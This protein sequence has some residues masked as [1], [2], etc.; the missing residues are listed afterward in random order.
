MHQPCQSHNW[1]NIYDID[2]TA[3]DDQF[4]M[5]D[6]DE[7]ETCSDDFDSSP[8][9]AI[10]C[11][12]S[13]GADQ[14]A[15]VPTPQTTYLP[16]TPR[17]K[18]PPNSPDAPTHND[19]E[20]ES[21]LR[22]APQR[23]VSTAPRDLW[24]DE[25][26]TDDSFIT[27]DS[28]LTARSH[29]LDS[30]A[31]NLSDLD[32]ASDRM[33]INGGLESR[34][35][36][37]NFEINLTNFGDIIN[38]HF[39]SMRSSSVGEI[40]SHSAT[41]TE[42]PLSLDQFME[43]LQN[44]PSSQFS[45]DS[46]PYPADNLTRK[47]KEQ[48]TV[49]PDF[50]ASRSQLSAKRRRLKLTPADAAKKKDVVLSFVSSDSDELCETDEASRVPEIGHVNVT[51][52]GLSGAGGVRVR[53]QSLPEKYI[54]SPARGFALAGK[55]SLTTEPD[56][57]LDHNRHL[58]RSPGQDDVGIWHQATNLHDINSS[59]GLLGTG[60]IP[61]QRFLYIPEK[62][63]HVT[64]TTDSTIPVPH[65]TN[66]VTQNHPDS[67]IQN[68]HQVNMQPELCA[69][70]VDDSYLKSYVRHG[71]TLITCNLQES[72]PQ[73]KTNANPAQAVLNL[74]SQQSQEYHMLSPLS[75]GSTMEPE[76]GVVCP[77]QFWS[78]N[79]LTS[80]G[81]SQNEDN[82]VSEFDE[83]KDENAVFAQ[84]GSFLMEG[85]NRS[86]NSTQISALEASVENNLQGEFGYGLQNVVTDAQGNE[87]I[88]PISSLIRHS[89]DN[90]ISNLVQ[91]SSSDV[92]LAEQIIQVDAD[93]MSSLCSQATSSSNLDSTNSDVLYTHD[94]WNQEIIQN[95]KTESVGSQAEASMPNNEEI[96]LDIDQ[97]DIIVPFSNETYIQMLSNT[98]LPHNAVVTENAV[99]SEDAVLHD[100]TVLSGDVV[101]TEDAVLHEN[102]M[103]PESVVL[104][105]NTVLPESVVLTEDAV[106]HDNTELPE[107]ADPGLVEAHKQFKKTGSMLALVKHELKCKIMSSRHSQGKGDIEIKFEPPKPHEV[108]YKM[109][110]PMIPLLS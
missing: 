59:G 45:Q 18:T 52:L 10:S 37:E 70:S 20:A 69:L 47:R 9:S 103:L 5:S 55:F 95:I 27:Y 71:S 4:F 53:H 74:E 92:Y 86:F 87:Y 73:Q 2:D 25:S 67:N 83:S 12:P 62:T 56:N 80:K 32:R 64:P 1:M 61:D 101:M 15:F 19:A 107:N 89:S 102:T 78:M 97:Q 90:G 21:E 11:P 54:H 30:Y 110:F 94:L 28:I 60:S 22:Q 41:S 14:D 39:S 98:V 46:M 72:S 91:G 17:C 63:D 33:D 44:F 82:R 57:T 40:Q 108:K 79:V 66:H 35:S 13:V 104:A 29:R 8:P 88:G 42:A 31:S 34:F 7:T 93:Q 96:P 76:P 68:F 43:L 6:V 3:H 49:E 38:A 23:C 100:N 36:V 106:L 24:D 48:E 99:F 50:S 65:L 84:P 26:D 75:A 16:Y 109:K 81:L 51:G 105:E 58:L 77:L 85:N